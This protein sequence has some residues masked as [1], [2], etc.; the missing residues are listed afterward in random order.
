LSL[1]LI[2]VITVIIQT[3]LLSQGSVQVPNSWKIE[4]WLWMI[5]KTNLNRC[6]LSGSVLY[7]AK[8]V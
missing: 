6:L 5:G 3:N 4:K 1:L 7:L 8:D 2:I